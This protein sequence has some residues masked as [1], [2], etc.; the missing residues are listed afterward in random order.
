MDLFAAGLLSITILTICGICFF[1]LICA[2]QPTIL[3]FDSFFLRR[4]LLLLHRLSFRYYQQRTRARSLIIAKTHRSSDSIRRKSSTND[5]EQRAY[6]KILERSVR[7][8]RPIQEEENANKQWRPCDF[9]SRYISTPR[10][11]T[12]A[13][14]QH[15]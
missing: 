11:S 14:V 13:N 9:L 10:T 2:I 7:T 12:S 8:G 5:A 4:S 1:I 6:L 3:R 15:V